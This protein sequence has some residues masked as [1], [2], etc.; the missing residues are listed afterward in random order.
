MTE[1]TSCLLTTTHAADGGSAGSPHHAP[2]CTEMM[3]VTRLCAGLGMANLA[4]AAFCA[5]PT[6][7]SFSRSAVADSTGATSGATP[8][9]C[10]SHSMNASLRCAWQLHL[11]RPTVLADDSTSAALGLRERCI[12]RACKTTI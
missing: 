3:R 8:R 11:V 7:G 9:S 10:H 4:G 6:V 2:P 1:V 12:D 5:Y